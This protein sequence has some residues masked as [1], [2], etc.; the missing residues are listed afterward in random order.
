MKLEAEFRTDVPAETD[1][2]VTA[3]WIVFQIFSKHDKQSINF[4]FLVINCGRT[5]N[6]PSRRVDVNTGC[7]TLDPK[8]NKKLILMPYQRNTVANRG[9]AK[10]YFIA[11]YCHFVAQ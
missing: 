11:L 4:L 8:F 7:F 5:S 10:F 6:C 2:A 3:G 9:H 1:G